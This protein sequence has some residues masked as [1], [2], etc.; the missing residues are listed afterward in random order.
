[1][2]NRPSLRPCAA[3]RSKILFRD[4]T[5]RGASDPPGLYGAS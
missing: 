3:G 5:G 1:M 2:L 4:A